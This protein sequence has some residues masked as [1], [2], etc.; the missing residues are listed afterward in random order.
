MGPDLVCVGNSR[1]IAV[2]CCTV[3]KFEML[4]KVQKEED[5]Q[6]YRVAVESSLDNIKDLI[7]CVKGGENFVI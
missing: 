2:K 6:L 5:C 1:K 7:I 3:L 4:D